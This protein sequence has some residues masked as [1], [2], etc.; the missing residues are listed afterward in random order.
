MDTASL[1]EVLSDLDPTPSSQGASP[2]SF[3]EVT[4]G[5]NSA[6]QA[7]LPPVAPSAISQVA[8]STIDNRGGPSNGATVTAERPDQPALL[9]M[10]SRS[11][12][13]TQVVGDQ[14]SGKQSVAHSASSRLTRGGAL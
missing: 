1:E 13:D 12:I 10:Q 6:P 2:S 9:T 3:E 8:T 11:L 14:A 4:D 7:E 5:S